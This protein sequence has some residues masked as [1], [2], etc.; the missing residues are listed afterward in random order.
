[1]LQENLYITTDQGIF[2]GNYTEN[3]KSSDNWDQIFED[4]S[5]IQFL[6]TSP[7]LI[8]GNSSILQKQGNEWEDYCT[9]FTGNIIQAKRENNQIGI[10]TEEYFFEISGCEIDSFQI[11][12]GD[13]NNTSTH[14]GYD[15]RTFFTSFDYSEYGNVFLGIKDH[16]IL[17]LDNLLENKCHANEL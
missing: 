1:M 8:L 7:Q 4:N 15:F 11:V 12:F 14:F 6:P 5:A 17:Y 16:G 3:L 10:L 13:Q 2:V 9:G